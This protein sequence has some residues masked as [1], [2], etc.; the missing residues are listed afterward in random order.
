MHGGRD[1]PRAARKR[2]DE[3]IEAVQLPKAFGDRYPHELSGGQRQR[4]T[5]AR[6][7]ALQPK[8]L[9][10]DEPTSAL[11][12]SV[13]ARV[14]ELFLELQQDLG[15]AAL[16]ISH[17]LAV[18]DMLADRIAV[19]Y[20]GDLV[21]TG[22]TA[23]VLGAPAA[24]VHAAPARVAA[25]ARPGRAGRATAYAG[26][27][28]AGRGLTRR[29]PLQEARPTSS[30]AAPAS[31]AWSRSSSCTPRRTCA[32]RSVATAARGRRGRGPMIAVER[33]GGR[34]GRRLHRVPGRPGPADPGRRRGDPDG[35]AAARSSRSSASAAPASR[36]SPPPSPGA[37]RAARARAR[38][39]AHRRRRAHRPRPADPGLRASSRRLDAPDRSIGYLPQDAGDRAQPRPHRGR[40]HRRADL[41]PRPPLRPAGG[42]R[43]I[44]ARLRRRGAPAARH[45]APA[46]VGALERAA[47]ARR[48]GAGARARAAAPRRRR[49]GPRRRRARAAGRA[50][51]PGDLQRDRQFSAVVV[52]SDLR[53]ARALA[54][55]V[56]VMR[57]RP[58][59]RARHVR[60][61]ARRP[62]RPLRQGPRRDRGA[63]RR[64]SSGAE[65]LRAGRRR[66]ADRW[67]PAPVPARTG[68]RARERTDAAR[69]HRAVVP[70]AARRCRP[71]PQ[72][73]PVAV[74]PAPAD[75]PDAARPRP[76]TERPARAAVDAGRRRPSPLGTDTRGIVWLD[77][78]DPSGLDDALAP[79]PRRRV[80]AA[81]VRRA[82]TPSRDLIAARRPRA[83]HDGQG[84]L[85]RA[86]RR[87]RARADPRDAAGRCQ[88]RARASSWA[89]EPRGRLALRPARRRHR[90]RRHRARVPAA[91]RAVRRAT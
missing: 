43:C 21:E 9:I 30:D 39:S 51:G 2:V 56:A 3:L 71:G 52:S 23:Q 57:R 73:G 60:R 29:D 80:G 65:P 34:R 74:L 20:R 18:V 88:T 77:H 87:A 37:R 54:D 90:R 28:G 84:R 19:L 79:H 35:P 47:A 55:R 89:T 50:R 44:V 32:A 6:S 13:Q 72:S 11:D 4:A 38:P 1:A 41:R 63:P 15:F 17:D 49:A 33:P 48:P 25:G 26:A 62:R 82:S 42:R 91:A 31:T 14:L 75:R 22:T 69:G 68:P 66:R 10:A 40:G 85:R 58:P 76:S 45:D 7:L 12:V 86:G 59:G 70:T 83:A 81:A 61:G 16:F 24:P 67:P 78:R 46:N 64:T 5:L 27:T 8:L 53:E 36:P